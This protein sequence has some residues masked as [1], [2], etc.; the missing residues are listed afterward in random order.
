MTE[1]EALDVVTTTM[2]RLLKCDVSPD[3][4][5]E[6]TPEWDSLKHI[7]VIFELEDRL[8]VQFTEQEMAE[9]NSVGQIVQKVIAHH[10]A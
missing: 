8:D 10:A 4:T 9:L 2:Q 6:S 3:A 5:R 1:K 7:E